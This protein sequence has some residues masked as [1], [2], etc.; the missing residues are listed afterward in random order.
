MNQNNGSMEKSEFSNRGFMLIAGPCAIESAGQLEAIAQVL[1]EEKLP[2]MRGGI[3]KLRTHPD[4]FQGLGE[5]AIDL[6]VSMKKKYG[7]K[8]VSEITDPRYISALMNTVDFFQVGTRNM[9]NYEL[10]KELGGIKR[11]IILKRA[12]SATVKEWLLA[13]EYLARGG[14]E[15]IILCE[16]G[17]RTFEIA[18]RNTVDLSGALVAQK[19]SGWPVILDPSHGVGRMDLVI[20]MALAGVACGLDG[21]LIEI[22]EEPHKAL[23][24]GQQALSFEA[25]RI[26]M[27]K[28]RRLLKVFGRALLEKTILK[29]NNEERKT[30]TTAFFYR[31]EIRERKTNI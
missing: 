10:L 4:S 11:P 2:F 19:E 30:L 31:P 5:R 12:F 17:I 29:D 1:Q 23:S 7:L 25:F 8:L 20:P 16:R 27:N 22:H 6:V 13:A 9:Y 21:L 28:V 24:D 26:L 18:T 14:N 3:Y 15:N